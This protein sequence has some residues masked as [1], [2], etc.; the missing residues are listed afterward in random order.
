MIEY[1]DPRTIYKD[2][3]KEALTDKERLVLR[4]LASKVYEYSQNPEQKKKRELWKHH[5]N[6]ER[7]RPM[8]LVFPE[9]A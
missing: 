7:I 6:L 3:P 8:I 4:Q 1:I 2:A 5:N 9:G